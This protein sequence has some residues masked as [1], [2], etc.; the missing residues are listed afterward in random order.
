[1][2]EYCTSGTPGRPA[3]TAS[4]TLMSAVVI[5][6]MNPFAFAAASRRRAV[7]G[8]RQHVR[9]VSLHARVMDRRQSAGFSLPPDFLARGR[10][11]PEG[12][13]SCHQCHGGNPTS[14]DAAVAHSPHASQRHD[15][16][17]RRLPPGPVRG[18]DTG[19]SRRQCSLAK[20]VLAS[21]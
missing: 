17:V 19:R 3:R 20:M 8:R 6:A 15:P 18:A 2:T 4:Y 1:M 14:L 16:R 5:V 21:R 7:P 12:K 11:L 10:T 9:F 13:S